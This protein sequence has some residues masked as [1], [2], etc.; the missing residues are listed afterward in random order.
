MTPLEQWADKKKVKRINSH[1]CGFC[2]SS[3][4][5]GRY[6]YSTFNWFLAM[7]KAD[8]DS[9]II[10]LCQPIFKRQINKTHIIPL[11]VLEILTKLVET[12]WQQN[13]YL[14]QLQWKPQL[15]CFYCQLAKFI[16]KTILIRIQCRSH[17]GA[18][19]PPHCL[20]YRLTCTKWQTCGH[21]PEFFGDMN[22]C[23]RR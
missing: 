11:T 15:C 9:R 6:G 2:P 4:A 3:G 18:Y 7:S 23:Q 14:Q 19:G 22:I 17:W 5:S 8:S 12:I 13:L 21:I 10:A 16:S 20:I 1:Q